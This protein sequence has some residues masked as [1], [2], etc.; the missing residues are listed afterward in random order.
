M[1]DHL[2]H[3]T[4]VSSEELRFDRE[5]WTK[6]LGPI[7]KMWGSIYKKDNFRNMKIKPGQLNSDD[8]VDSFIYME[9][10]NMMSTL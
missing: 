9:A 10:F 3:L 5:K 1:I 6:L 7:L 2:K 8:P 4:A